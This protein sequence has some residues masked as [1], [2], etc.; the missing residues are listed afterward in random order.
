[1]T[2]AQELYDSGVAVDVRPPPAT[3]VVDASSLGTG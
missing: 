1:M 3:E 2:I